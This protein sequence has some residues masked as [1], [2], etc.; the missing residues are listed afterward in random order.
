M[1]A[2]RAPMQSALT[3]K[4]AMTITTHHCAECGNPTPHA[5]YCSDQ[6]AQT[7]RPRTCNHCSDPTPHRPY[8]SDECDDAA[9]WAKIDDLHRQNLQRSIDRYASM[10]WKE[11]C[12]LERADRRAERKA[13][14]GG[15]GGFLFIGDIPGM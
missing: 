12:A 1:C 5:P 11:F 8:C 14:R 15:G 2:A 3:A 6:C 7:P 4:A 13:H 10:P 9:A